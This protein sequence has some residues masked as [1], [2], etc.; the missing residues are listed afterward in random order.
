M[1]TIKQH[2]IPQFVMRNFTDENDRLCVIDK[3]S[4]PIRIIH[5]KTTGI[6]FENDIYETKNIDGSYFDRNVIEKKF[7]QIESN[8]SN[9]LK[10]INSNLFNEKKLSADEEVALAVFIALQLVR[11][12]VLKEMLYAN[13]KRAST[14]EIDKK[15]FDEAIYRMMLFSRENGFEYLKQNGL[16][17]SDKT[18]EQLKGESMLEHTASFILNECAIYIL[19]APDNNS[20]ILTD[21]PILIDSFLDAKYIFPISPKM[22]ICCCLFEEANG[23]ELGG[24]IQ[25]QPEWINKINKELCDKAKRWIICKKN[26]SSDIISFIEDEVK[27]DKT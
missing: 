18:R 7:A 26:Y 5:P 25:A 14:S 22:A 9:I 3:N 23:N 27:N 21:L 16:D 6:L 1:P 2:F 13:S 12:P 11:L 24:F 17:L 20:Y 15:M 19:I 4:S 8:V 10:E